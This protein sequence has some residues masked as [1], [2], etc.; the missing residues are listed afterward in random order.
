MFILGI[1]HN[2]FCN[3]GRKVEGTCMSLKFNVRERERES[4]V[5]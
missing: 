4:A 1:T 5:P 2:I 3:D